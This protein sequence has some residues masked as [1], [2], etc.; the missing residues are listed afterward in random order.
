MKYPKAIEDQLAEVTKIIGNWPAD[1][2]V[3]AEAVINWILQFDE[4]DFDLALRVIRNL[5]VIG[6]KDIDRGLRV[7][8]SKLSRKAIEKGARITS[9]NTLFAAMGDVGKSGAMISY[10]FRMNAEVSEENFLSPDTIDYIRQGKIENIVLID[11]IIGTGHQATKEINSVATEL[12]PLGVKNIFV[13]TVCGMREAIVEI[14]ENT[15]AF[16][17]SAFEYSAIDTASSL[18]SS[19]YA[20]V[21]HDSRSTL[22]ERLTSYGK[23]C[24]PRWPLG[25]GKIAGL[26][27][28]PYNTPN[29]TLPVLWSDNNEWIP[30]FRRVKRLNGIASY[31]KQFKKATDQKA[32]DQKTKQNEFTPP[33]LDYTLTLFV[34]G[35]RDE[36]FFDFFVSRVDLAKA[37]GVPQIEVV[38][39]GSNVLSTRLVKN[40]VDTNKHAVFVVDDDYPGAAKMHAR[41][42]DIAKMLKLTP[43]FLALVDLQRVAREFPKLG[44]EEFNLAEGS[45]VYRRLEQ[46]IF[47][48]GTG[49]RVNPLL[50]TL[51]ENCLD[52]QAVN[53]FIDEL[54]AKIEA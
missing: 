32:N 20:D 12:I 11:D 43:N 34:E 46:T 49:D 22:L 10:H 17:F 26:I 8:F 13:L 19:F 23:V 37:V 52:H 31:E 41:V 6:Q 7:A 24:Y 48:G 29:T 28:F 3:T 45:E 39:L 27:V 53:E 21:P 42:E 9:R 33:E 25:Y 16:T 1:A 18:D 47:R 14:E 30:L 38:S 50:R 35:K 54:R 5:N 44:I 2:D 4:P 40:L 15:K 51:V 36:Q